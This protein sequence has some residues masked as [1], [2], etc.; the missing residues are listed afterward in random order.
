[1]EEIKE[2]CRVALG[3]MGLILPSV[4]Q[5]KAQT[6]KVVWKRADLYPKQEAAIFDRRRISVIEAS[7][8][9]GKT[10]GCITW[11]MEMAMSGRLGVNYWWVAHWIQE[12]KLVGAGEARTLASSVPPASDVPAKA[13]ETLGPAGSQGTGQLR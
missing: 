3:E 5:V 6:Q 8:K 9:S 4:Q 2:T 1:M 13:T 12:Q 10:E 7:T 11:L